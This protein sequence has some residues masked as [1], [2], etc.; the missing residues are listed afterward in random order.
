[1]ANA[2]DRQYI[3]PDFMTWI[4]NHLYQTDVASL[5]SPV[6][7]QQTGSCHCRDIGGRHCLRGS[8]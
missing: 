5:S 3:A 1:M 2:S 7:S 4:I 8:L 6:S